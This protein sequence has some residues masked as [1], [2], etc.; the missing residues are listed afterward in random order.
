MTTKIQRCHVCDAATGR[1]EED[2]LFS[3]DG[4]PLCEE[5]FDRAE[6]MAQSPAVSASGAMTEAQLARET[7]FLMIEATIR[8][9]YAALMQRANICF[10]GAWHFN[11]ENACAAELE[12]LTRRKK[13]TK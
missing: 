10:D 13:A 2:S 9:K 11:Y 1:C 4:N 5:C 12:M 6:L 8:M 7:A 3:S